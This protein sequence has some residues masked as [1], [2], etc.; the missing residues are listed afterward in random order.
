MKE[1]RQREKMREGGTSCPYF[2][3]GMKL[4]KWNQI[5]DR[6]TEDAVGAET[7]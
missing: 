4:K 1:I 5:V 6:W 2:Q 7:R 3:K